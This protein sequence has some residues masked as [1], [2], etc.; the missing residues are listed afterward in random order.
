[1]SAVL[2]YQMPKIYRR[3]CEES[4]LKETVH[5]PHDVFAIPFAQMQFFHYFDEIIPLFLPS[6]DWHKDKTFR[7]KIAINQLDQLSTFTRNKLF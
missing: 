6:L 5:V 3:D 2:H 4:V 7:R 1:M